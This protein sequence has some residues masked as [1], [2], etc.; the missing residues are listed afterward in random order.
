MTWRTHLLAG[1]SSLW[2]LDALQPGVPPENIGLL[3]L[4]AGF[5]ALLPDLDAARSKIRNMKVGG[6]EPFAVP[7]DLLHRTFGHRGP[8]HSLIGLFGVGLTLSL[9]TGRSA[10]YGAA[11]MVLIGGGAGVASFLV[12]SL[13]GRVVG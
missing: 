6:I 1:I 8:L 3:A 2:L 10:W 4:I 13:L 5:G 9:F 11:R 7:A 12:G